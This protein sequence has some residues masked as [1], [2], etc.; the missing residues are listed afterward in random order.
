MPQKG[1]Y[2]YL[3]KANPKLSVGWG[4]YSFIIST[5]PIV[6]DNNDVFGYTDFDK[7]EIHLATGRNSEPIPEAIRRL[8]VLHEIF[9]VIADQVGLSAEIERRGL[10]PAMS[11]E[12]YVER[13]SKGLLMLLDLNPELFKHLFYYE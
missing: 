8:T 7:M 6:I 4:E 11:N 1:I 10:L 2:D 12:D 3:K 13:T 9:H 5:E